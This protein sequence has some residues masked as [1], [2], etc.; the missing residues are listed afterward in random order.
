MHHS[1]HTFMHS[2]NSIENTPSS[3]ANNSSGSSDILQVSWNLKVHLCLHNSP[4]PVPILSQMN[5]VHASPYHFL[6]IHFN[7]NHPPTSRSA[8]SLSCSFSN[9]NPITHQHNVRRRVNNSF[10]NHQIHYQ[11][12]LEQ[13]GEKNVCEL[14]LRVA[15]MTKICC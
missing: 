12:L 5:P 8:Q 9:R 6:K 10:L 14:S 1:N 4:P 13:K 15:G 3:E 2:T 7:T 11:F